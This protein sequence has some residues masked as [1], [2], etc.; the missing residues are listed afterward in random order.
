MEIKTIDL[1]WYNGATSN[2]GESVF[3][4]NEASVNARAIT[5]S[6]KVDFA[7]SPGLLRAGD[8]KEG[9]DYHKEVVVAKLVVVCNAESLLRPPPVPARPS[10]SIPVPIPG[11][12]APSY[13]AGEMLALDEQKRKAEYEQQQG[14]EKARLG[15][16]TGVNEGVTM[17]R[18]LTSKF[19]VQL[20]TPS[21][22]TGP[23]NG[24]AFGMLMPAG[25]MPPGAGIQP[26]Q[27]HSG[28]GSHA[29][30]NNRPYVPGFEHTHNYYN[31]LGRPNLELT[32]LLRPTPP[33]THNCAPPASHPLTYSNNTNTLPI[34]PRLMLQHPTNP[35]NNNPN[36]AQES[37]NKRG[38][39]RYSG[40]RHYKSEPIVIS[41]DSDSTDTDERTA[42]TSA[43]ITRG[44]KR[45]RLQA[46]STTTTTT[47]TTAN[48][49][50]PTTD[51]TTKPNIFPNL[52]N[53]IT[54]LKNKSTAITHPSPHCPELVLEDDIIAALEKEASG[55]SSSDAL[56][57]MVERG[58][59]NPPVQPAQPDQ[60]NQAEPEPET[61]SPP[62]YLL[63]LDDEDADDSDDDEEEELGDIALDENRRLRDIRN[64]HLEVQIPE[65]GNRDFA[66][67]QKISWEEGMALGSSSAPARTSS[68]NRGAVKPTRGGG[69]G[70]QPTRG[71]RGGVG[72]GIPRSRGRPRKENPNPT[73]PKK[74]PSGR[75]RGRPRKENP[76][77]TWIPTGRPKG[78]PRKV[79]VVVEEKGV[80]EEKAVVEEAAVEEA[81]VEQ[82]AVVEEAVVE[83]KEVVD[84]NEVVEE[85]VVE[86][87]VVVEGEV[88][89]GTVVSEAVVPE[90]IVPEAVVEEKAV[91]EEAVVEEA[92]V[93]EA[94]VPEAVVDEG[95][96]NL[97]GSEV[98]VNST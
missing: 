25:R 6:L 74:I 44:A 50:L 69:G 36:T 41:S 27:D 35:N 28:V 45:Q 96:M 67:W 54:Y 42:D 49:T 31:T 21:P 23:S 80:G 91:V 3:S 22:S 73:Q 88:V 94:V 17:R 33:A 2:Q 81:V 82:K 37:R 29:L 47:T 71:G 38:R 90:A 77:P 89:P 10:P 30:N 78:R 1:R 87:S 18:E 9:G 75:P 24:A 34:D 59:T 48:H 46:T 56:V 85:A 8:W 86:E 16:G 93:L 60:A 39:P 83:Q 13:T 58:P 63:I 19:Y 84:E 5:Q 98:R 72:G 66:E 76:K 61:E 97:D 12:P 57:M 79:P 68:N 7:V 65:R 51:P 40:T 4:L 62:S 15:L 14:L 20:P 92:V 95:K 32:S 55:E 11:A 53:I 64:N 43:V 70:M 52:P 26:A